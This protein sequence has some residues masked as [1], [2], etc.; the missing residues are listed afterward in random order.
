[1]VH[2]GVW[3]MGFKAFRAFFVEFV[4]VCYSERTKKLT[5]ACGWFEDL[6]TWV[7]LQEIINIVDNRW[8]CEVDSLIASL[9]FSKGFWSLTAKRWAP[10]VGGLLRTDFWLLFFKY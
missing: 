10:S 5:G 6:S 9:L 4:G 3:E 7:G 1:M 2:I 8:R